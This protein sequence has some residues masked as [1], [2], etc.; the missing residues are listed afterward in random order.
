MIRRKEEEEFED[1]LYEEEIQNKV[2]DKKEVEDIKSEDIFKTHQA[3][4][5]LVIWAL[6]RVYQMKW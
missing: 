5:I 2:K 3:G 6:S 4:N 1:D